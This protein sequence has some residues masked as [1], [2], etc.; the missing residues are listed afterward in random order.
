M[1]LVASN[2][3]VDAQLRDGIAAQYDDAQDSYDRVLCQAKCDNVFHLVLNYAVHGRRWVAGVLSDN[4]PMQSS[5]CA[6]SP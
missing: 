5:L 4:A 2:R 1:G 3:L 6:A